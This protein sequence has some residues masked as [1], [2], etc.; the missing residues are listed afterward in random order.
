[1]IQ[2]KEII[3]PLANGGSLRCGEGG[4]HQWGGYLRIC[5]ADGY[6]IAF[7]DALEI[8]DN[9]ETTLGACFAMC[10]KPIPELLK[11]LKLTR[12]VDDCWIPE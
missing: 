1:M 10:E 9:A 5:D 6:E 3:I 7:W 11:T 8:E 12:V 2:D 4:I